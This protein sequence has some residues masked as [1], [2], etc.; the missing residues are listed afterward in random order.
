MIK[1]ILGGA[2]VI[3]AGRYLS[4]LTMASNNIVTQISVQIRKITLSG[5]QLRANVRLQNPNPVRLRIQ[6]PFVQIKYKGRLIGNSIVQ[7][8]VIDL[9]PN[10][11]RI[12]ELDI[13]SAGWISLLQ[14]LGTELVQ[15]IRNGQGV[16][17]QITT[18]TSTRVNNLPFV[19]E[20]LL[21]I[22]I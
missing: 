8:T 7:D 6:H 17:F 10:S 9:P 19:K 4:Q 15:K 21:T 12:F 11:E 16:N 2:A 5:I 13:R 1:W 20:E 22:S 3:F 14:V 18:T